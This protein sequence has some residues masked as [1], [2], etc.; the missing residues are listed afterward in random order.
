VRR[1]DDLFAVYITSFN[2]GP[3]SFLLSYA[4]EIMGDKP[5]LALELDEHGADAGYITRI[6]AFLDVTRSWQPT[7]APALAAS[8]DPSAEELRRRRIWIPSMHPVA[9]RL[10]AAAFRSFG[11]DAHALPTETRADLEA[12]QKLSRGCECLPMRTTLGAFV[13]AI[14]RDPSDR[15]HAVFMPTGKG[16]CRFGQ[17]VTLERVFFD[18]TG[19][20]DVMILSPSSD[21]SYFGLPE[22]LRRKL[23]PALV[24][25]DVLYKATCRV[26][27]YE[28]TRGDTDAALEKWIVAAEAAFEGG[29]DLLEVIHRA[30]A[31][32]ADI[33]TRDERRPLVGIV[34]EI[35][36]RNN[37]F[38]NENVVRAVERAGGEA[39]SAPVSEW[40]LFTASE[41]LRRFM[42]LPKSMSELLAHGGRILKSRW[43]QHVEH[44]FHQ[45]MGAV[46]T[47]REEPPIQDTVTAGQHYLPFNVGGETI[48]SLGRSVHFIRQGAA[49]IVNVSP[50]SCMAGTVCA[51]LFTRMERELQVPVVNLFYD[52]SGDENARLEVFLANL[53]GATV[54]SGPPPSRSPRSFSL[55]NLF[56]GAPT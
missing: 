41:D 2:C 32:F 25:G 33:P 31:D 12:G 6:E 4:E 45:A 24:A 5:M 30:G 8:S 55:P 21:N 52:G 42:T 26:R 51:S 23:W 49:L 48:L 43:L 54:R 38:S 37:L 29:S 19:R 27:P 17:Y 35:Y 16:P 39:W 56:R 36:V 46:L 11:F 20:D 44:S 40:I 14:D 7:P 3:D 47:D 13:H 22:S 34:G 9:T 28:V 53:D 1:R 18:R 50:F 10:F 15:Q